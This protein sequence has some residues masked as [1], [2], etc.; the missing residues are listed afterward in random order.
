MNN[1]KA[2]FSSNCTSNGSVTQW[3]TTCDLNGTGYRPALITF[4]SIVL[5]GG[6]IGAIVITWK[7]KNYRKSV[8]ST[9]MVNLIF[10]HV[11]FLVTVPFRIS[12]YGLG[13][14]KF[15]LIF[16]KLVDAT[17]HA[18]MY[19]SFVFYVIIVVIRMI[20]F[21]NEKK[22]VQFYQPWHASAVSLV[23]WFLVLMGVF[24]S[25]QSNYDN[26]T[27]NNTTR[28]FLVHNNPYKAHNKIQNY[29]CV[30]VVLGVFGV[31]LVIQTGVLIKLTIQHQGTLR[32][33]HQFGAQMKTLFFVLIMIW[34]VPFLGFRILYINQ[35]KCCSSVLHV[36]NEVFL[37]LSALC[38]F[39]ALVLL[40]ASH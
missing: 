23:I 34:F 14:W 33:Q 4:Y 11:I 24:S 28:C 35:I 17:I 40:V 3:N 19:L 38:C 36:I 15:G 25:F 39:D 31:L 9:A 22:T 12:Y 16:C 30:I 29:L 1:T 27:Q 8:T 5:V 2:P 37:A 6:T 21:F 26:S 7:I 20:S 13:E 10:I 18:H 32:K